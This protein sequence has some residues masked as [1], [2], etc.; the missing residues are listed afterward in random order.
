MKLYINNH[1]MPDEI[2]DL[3]R[4]YERLNPCFETVAWH[5]KDGHPGCFLSAIY[6]KNK[7]LSEILIEIRC[8]SE[9]TCG[10]GWYE[11]VE[12]G[13]FHSP[14]HFDISGIKE[15]PRDH[16]KI[17]EW[18]DKTYGKDDTVEG[19]S[20]NSELRAFLKRTMIE[21]DINLQWFTGRYDQFMSWL[22]ENHKEQYEIVCSSE[23]DV[24]DTDSV[25]EKKISPDMVQEIVC[26]PREIVD[27]KGMIEEDAN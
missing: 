8:E 3:Y 16:T 18:F 20:Y 27:G 2:R 26:Q 6:V 21:N 4:E 10:V 1:L 23:R 11:A 12:Q 5:W 15:L 17:D 25:E 19:S 7:D 13:K 14:A 22:E 9:N 24:V